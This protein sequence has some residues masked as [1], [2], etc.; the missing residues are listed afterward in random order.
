MRGAAFIGQKK[1]VC[2]LVFYIA[3]LGYHAPIDHSFQD[4]RKR[5]AVDPACVDEGGLTHTRILKDVNKH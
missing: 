5:A 2:P 3:A 1:C 4:F